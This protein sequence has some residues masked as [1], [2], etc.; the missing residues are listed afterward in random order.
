MWNSIWHMSPTMWVTHLSNWI[1]IFGEEF[2]LFSQGKTQHPKPFF[3]LNN[4]LVCFFNLFHIKTKSGC[5]HL[6][7][8]EL[9]VL[10]KEEEISRCW[11]CKVF[12][13]YSK[14]YLHNISNIGQY[15]SYIK[16]MLYGIE[17]HIIF[18]TMLRTKRAVEK[19]IDD[20]TMSLSR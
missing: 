4:K 6:W 12:T 17:I 1:W 9:W 11:S 8:R 20:T 19:V 16:L 13:Q 10:G 2:N 7:K 14:Y 15:S 18:L 5:L 3:I